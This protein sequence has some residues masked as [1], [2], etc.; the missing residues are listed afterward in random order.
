MYSDKYKILILYIQKHI[1]TYTYNK[2]DNHF[3]IF[4][5]LKN[6]KLV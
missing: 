3:E 6:R 2:N 5:K 1:I 4:I